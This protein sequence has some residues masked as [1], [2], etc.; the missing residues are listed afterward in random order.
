MSSTRKLI[1]EFF[2]VFLIGALVGGLIMWSYSDTQ[3]T[4]F[5]SRT[6]NP[7]VF[8][9]RI[10]KKYADEYHLSA[11]EIDRVQPLIKE[12]AQHIYQVRHQ[13]GVDIVGTLD[14]YHTQIAA[15]LTP[16]H[17]AAYQ[18]AMT[19]RHKKLSSLLL[20]DPGSPSGDSK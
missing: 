9:A 2:G 7:D 4:T 14:Q 10:D 1:A 16:E 13:F 11:D 3:L 15:Q 17:R 12:M 6:N 19:D 8:V 5:M 20:L 18:A